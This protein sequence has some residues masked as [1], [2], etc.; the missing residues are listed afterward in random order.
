MSDRY[1]L[2]PYRVRSQG[3]F[4]PMLTLL[5]ATAFTKVT[6][7]DWTYVGG[8]SGG[9]SYSSLKQIDATNVGR[10]REA[11]TFHTADAGSDIPMQATPIVVSGTL[12]FVTAGHRV[13]ALDPATGRRKWTF[14]SR[15]QSSA[16]GHARSSRGVAFWQDRQDP[17]R[18]RILYGTPDGRILSID[19]RSG[20]ADPKFH[21]VN[22]RKE[23]GTQGYVGVSAAPTVFEDLVYVGIASDEGPSAAPGHIM[24]FSVKTGKRIWK[25]DVLTPDQISKGAGAAGA[26]SGYVVDERRGILFAATG[27]AAPD[28]DG[29]DR[30][31]DNLYANCVLAIDARTGRKLWHFQTVHHDLWDHDNASKPVLCK[32]R[33]NG[34]DLETVAVVTKTGFCFVFD[35]VTG[36]P[37]FGVKEVP[38]A[39]STI[40][41]EVVSPTQ[42]EPILPPPLAPNLF[43]EAD[44]TNLSSESRDFVKKLLANLDYGKKYLPPSKRGTVV[45]PGYFGGSPWSG[46]SFN[47]ATNTLFVNTNNVPGIMSNPADYR[48]LVDQDGYPG[49]RPPW[50]MLTAIDMNTGRFRWRVPLGEHKELTQR[51]VPRTGTLNLGGTLTTAGGLVFVGATCD[52]MFRAFDAATG[53]TLVELPLPASAYATPATYEVGGQQYVVISASGGGYAKRFGF[54]RGPVSDAL[55]C[56][57]LPP[58]P[59]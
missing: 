14:D 9:S 12:Y 47:P 26:W 24:A 8:D 16:S 49:V 27:S 33:R 22:L 28:F 54:D 6:P 1:D 51:G 10:L 48:M 34:R 43:T 7:S 59:R 57:A 4:H 25:F 11:W 40:P 38:A 3:N 41:G 13:V 46:A 53:K 37:V 15:N 50:G 35:R 52:Q 55:V 31:G 2:D 21:E 58:S 39:P 18:T 32:T 44:I 20:E 36:K 45:S 5:A 19:A 42:P 23:L 29:R 56:F 30:P 17:R